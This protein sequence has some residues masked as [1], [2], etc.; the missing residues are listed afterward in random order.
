M[1]GTIAASM[2]LTSVAHSAIFTQSSP[3]LLDINEAIQASEGYAHYP[4]SKVSGAQPSGFIL[5]GILD[6][7]VALPKVT[8]PGELLA[9]VKASKNVLVAST[10]FV[11]M[12]PEVYAELARQNGV[13]PLEFFRY[14]SN[15][16]G[17]TDEQFN[18]MIEEQSQ[19]IINV[20]NSSKD[21][22][23]VS[24]EI[25]ITLPA[26]VQVVIK[27]VQLRERLEE[28]N[29]IIASLTE[30]QQ[31]VVAEL[32]SAN[33]MISELQNIIDN[34][35]V[36]FADYNETV[37]RLNNRVDMISAELVRVRATSADRLVTIWDLFTQ[38]NALRQDAD[39]L[40]ST[41]NELQAI[42]DSIPT[43]VSDAEAIAYDNGF[44]AGVAS[45]D[46]TSDN[47]EV[48]ADGFSAGVASVDVSDTSD[49]YNRGY[50]A[51]RQF[52]VLQS[53]SIIQSYEQAIVNAVANERAAV[54][55]QLRSRVAGLNGNIEYNGTYNVELIE[56][57][58][59]TLNVNVASDPLSI[60]SSIRVSVSNVDY[61]FTKRADGTIFMQIG[62]EIGT[63]AGGVTNFTTVNQ[64][65]SRTGATIT[66]INGA[67]TSI[68]NSFAHAD[69][70]AAKSSSAYDATPD[71]VNGN[72]VTDY[73]TSRNSTLSI[74]GSD[75]RYGIWSTG[76]TV[77][78]YTL[79]G[80]SSGATNNV[81]DAIN[82]ALESSFDDGYDEGYA[83]GYEDGFEDGF[84]AGRSTQ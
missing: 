16:I 6:T 68:S 37:E 25:F 44:S 63:T 65:V 5:S 17:M 77:T 13:T 3:S 30:E 20:L 15:G 12:I 57:I 60:L 49:P 52:G 56:G 32:A 50:A 64:V 40:Q 7:G 69:L 28:A 59:Y 29:S 48:Y 83:D 71:R 24:N 53:I 14:L 82:T 42:V 47:A 61:L 73:D 72:D 45:V 54:I 66:S 75:V 35:N 19:A 38:A 43:T 18:M 21:V 62:D 11:F 80:T 1:T 46:I 84:T 23:P 51:G 4:K 55:E 76:D 39:N 31:Q 36:L 78:G 67:T 81:L 33:M 70:D 22:L 10:D 27:D 34:N 9:A 8:N 41:V 58:T 26:E 2:L 79:G 74:G